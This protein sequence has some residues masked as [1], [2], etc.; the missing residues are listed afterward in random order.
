MQGHAETCGDIRRHAQTC[1]DMRRHAEMCGDMRGHH[2]YKSLVEGSGPNISQL[3]LQQSCC[4]RRCC[5]CHRRRRC[6][7]CAAVAADAAVFFSV[8]RDARL[9]RL[10]RTPAARGHAQHPLACCEPLHEGTRSTRHHYLDP[11]VFLALFFVLSPS[12]VPS[13]LFFI[14]NMS[15]FACSMV[16]VSDPSPTLVLL[17]EALDHFCAFPCLM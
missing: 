9:P 8:R 2:V 17:H 16:A 3:M 12:S 10:L 13:A 4:R 6:C 14:S 5:C 1:G 11:F 7:C 15:S